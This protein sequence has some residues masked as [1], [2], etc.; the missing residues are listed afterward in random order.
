MKSVIKHLLIL[1]MLTL[2]VCQAEVVLRFQSNIDDKA[3]RL[4]DVLIIKND[5]Q[6]W[7]N[8]PLDSH[9]TPGNVLTKTT[10][11]KWMTQH[12]EHM[13]ATWQGKTHINIKPS[14]RSSKKQW[15]EKAHTALIEKL[16]THYL[17]VEATPLSQLKDNPYALRDFT[18][19]A[20]VSFPTSKR[21]CVW[22]THKKNKALRIAV[23]FNVSAYANVMV[24]KRDM[25][26][27]TP[28]Q[29][30]DF[31]L[32]ERNIAGLKAM[33]V[34]TIQQP[35]WLKSSI[36]NGTILLENHLKKPPLVVHGQHIKIAV[37]HHN[38]TIVMD[39]I[40]LAD[41]YSGDIITVKNPLN[42]K[43]FDARISGVQQ[44]EITS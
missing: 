19:E 3:T 27:N 32:K 8:L 44:A 28:I 35:I 11:M 36:R 21:V 30:D 40:A 31:S 37:H 2:N 38:I 1:L 20:H 5:K 10:I 16:G 12:I 43:T 29:T 39:A 42:Q 34:Q 23:W 9:P 41:G 24:A 4:G 25:H 22:L 15:I 17:R 14:K 7:S 6:H 13:N 26:Y 18:T 33:P